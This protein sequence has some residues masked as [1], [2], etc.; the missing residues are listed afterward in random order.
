MKIRIVLL[1]AVA[2][3]VHSQS[4]FSASQP[5]F[6]SLP[7]GLQN[8]GA[9]FARVLS[10]GD[11]PARLP[12]N[13]FGPTARTG[14]ATASSTS[15]SNPPP[16]LGSDVDPGAQTCGLAPPFCTRSRYRSIDGSCNNLQR[17]NWG[18]P[19]T[20]YGRLLPYNYADGVYAWPRAK[21][22]RPLPNPR[23]ISLRLFPDRQLVD[24]IWNLNAQQ[25]G[26]IITHDM[27]LTAGVTQTHKETITCCDDNGQLAA[28]VNTNP[29]CAP[30]LIPPNDPIHAPLGTQCMNFV[31]TTTTQDRR[32][33]PLGA[34]AEPLSVVTAYM[35]L[36][37]VYGSSQG[38]AA[39]IRAGTGGRLLTVLR[40]GQEWPPQDNN[41]TLTCESAQSPNEPC[42]LTGVLRP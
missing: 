34:P 26:Q 31:R 37:L 36:S 15:F 10:G 9:T 23:E 42:Y 40:G 16:P 5:F 14:Q 29:Q 12:V 35:D 39:P 3:S 22:G 33:K 41:I 1:L 17:P 21:S 6:N 19:L 8:L 13:G 28:D 7:A 4:F 20:P 30:I 27:S 38:Q 11:P 24:P 25:W 2:S 18:V 32:C